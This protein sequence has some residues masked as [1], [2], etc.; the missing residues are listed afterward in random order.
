MFEPVRLP[1]FT[2][3]VEAVVIAPKSL[4]FGTNKQVSFETVPIAHVAPEHEEPAGGGL[5]CVYSV[6]PDGCD[7][8]MGRQGQQCS[9]EQQLG[10]YQ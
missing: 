2:V 9:G 7:Q 6:G 5:Q 3:E 4:L 10:L 1:E 8:H